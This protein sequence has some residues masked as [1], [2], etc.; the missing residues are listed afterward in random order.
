[1]RET[2]GNFDSCNS[3][4][5]LGTRP[6]HEMHESKFRFV[7]RIEFICS[8][9]SNFSAHVSGISNAQPCG[10]SAETWRR[11]D[12][13]R[14][15]GEFP[16]SE[17]PSARLLIP[18]GRCLG[19]VSR[20]SLSKPPPVAGGGFDGTERAGTRSDGRKTGPAQR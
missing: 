18:R 16:E 14:R 11:R 10:S 3:C 4:Q 6:L 2:N 19:G 5:R 9:L 8:K 13:E 1:M 12:E 17:S 15:A 20:G 7:S